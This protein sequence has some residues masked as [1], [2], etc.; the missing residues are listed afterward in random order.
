MDELIQIVR[1]HLDLLD[2]DAKC[3]A[4]NSST[5]ATQK[6]WLQI[7]AQGAAALA[8]AS[9]DSYYLDMMCQL[10]GGVEVMCRLS[11]R[12]ECA[13]DALTA[14]VNVAAWASVKGGEREMDR[15]VTRIAQHGT[16]RAAASI[17]L[18]DEAV[19]RT[20][21]KLVQNATTS[22]VGCEALADQD[23]DLCVDMIRAFARSRRAFRE[24][25]L[26]ASFGECL[27]NLT[28]LST[29]I[30]QILLRR[31]SRILEVLLPQLLDAD[32]ARER[33]LG[34][35]AALKHCGLDKD[36][37]YYLDDELDATRVILRSLADDTDVAKLEQSERETLQEVLGRCDRREADPEVALLLLETLQCFCA[38]RRCRRRLRARSAYFVIRDA[39]LAFAHGDAQRDD[40]KGA[41]A[42]A[43]NVVSTGVLVVADTDDDQRD[44]DNDT[45]IKTRTSR[46]CADLA[47][48]LLRDEA[49]PEEGQSEFARA[50]H[51]FE[52]IS[53]S[54]RN[55]TISVSAAQHGRKDCLLVD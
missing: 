52:P 55:G 26:W 7:C 9:G 2:R 35:A 53:P 29:S 18:N 33:R 28:A 12:R 40:A 4:N 30:R 16:L 24:N 5:V 11:L 31:S 14:L 51:N 23:P 47:D 48:M 1:S 27:R 15:L 13:A 37:H 32:S 43:S 38:T 39:D 45:A 54:L 10:E 34:V 20:A 44:A 6:R 22:S 19:R 41:L 21:L 25:D 50:K 49:H 8:T 36:N 3:A 46:V 42:D 17:A